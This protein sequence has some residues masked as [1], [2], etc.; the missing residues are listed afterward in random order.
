VWSSFSSE[1]GFSTGE[2]DF[3]WTSN[4]QERDS[5]ERHSFLAWKNWII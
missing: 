2:V 5:G 1:K 4:P 3:S